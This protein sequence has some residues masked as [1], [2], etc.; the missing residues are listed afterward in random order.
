[1]KRYLILVLNIVA[2]VGLGTYYIR[3]DKQLNDLQIEFDSAYG[4]FGELDK[5]YFSNFENLNI[6]IEKDFNTKEFSDFPDSTKLKLIKQRRLGSYFYHYK[7][8]TDWLLKLVKV[9]L[10]E[11]LWTIRMLTIIGLVSFLVNGFLFFIN[12]K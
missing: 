12:R 10:E 2:L 4:E 1:M 5:R 9:N 11:Q 6:E 8:N 3:V 7:V